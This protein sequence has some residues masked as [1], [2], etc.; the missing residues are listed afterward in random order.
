MQ[1]ACCDAEWGKVCV[2][3]SNTKLVTFHVERNDRLIS[4]LRIHLERLWE[5]VLNNDP[6]PPDA[7]TAPK[8]LELVHG[9]Q[10]PESI[11]YIPETIQ[12]IWSN[13][14]GTPQ[15][16]HS[17]DIDAEIIAI[18]KEVKD[19][20]TRKANLRILIENEII[21]NNGQFGILR[22]GG[23]NQI[24]QFTVK[25]YDAKTVQAYDTKAH[26]KMTRRKLRG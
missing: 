24:A 12:T 15:M 10:E 11:V 16:L 17:V 4:N 26:F 7:T 20:E 18:T 3:L 25:H 13:E 23:G 14:D 5:R 21:K 22:D 9:P 8:I 2:V 1:M 19:L 6:P